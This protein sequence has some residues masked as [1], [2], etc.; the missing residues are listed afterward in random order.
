MLVTVA[1]LTALALAACG[2]D[3]DDENPD[4]DDSTAE[5]APTTTTT[6]PSTED[7]EDLALS[8]V[9]TIFHERGD[10]TDEIYQN[11]E[12]IDDPD[13]DHIDRLNELV[14]SNA[15]PTV[16]W[17]IEDAQDLLNDGHRLQ[18]TGELMTDR[19]VY[20]M[21]VVDADT[22]TFETCVMGDNQE[23]DQNGNAVSEPSVYG[24]FGIGEAHRV[25]G[26]WRIAEML[27]DPE[28]DLT[29]DHLTPGYLE[30]GACDAEF[31][32]DADFPR[33]QE[34]EDS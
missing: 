6:Q 11:P 15:E 7:N 23:V 20:R 2:D 22:I 21:E 12:L 28:Y 14:T 27:S 18:A 4:S 8:I 17:V 30:P 9:D 29:S 33:A 25:D 19:G 24:Q 1:S 10:L 5:P 26:I 32:D 3:S 31:G 34:E 13:S 16:D